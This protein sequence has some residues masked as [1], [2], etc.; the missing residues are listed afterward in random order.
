MRIPVLDTEPLES[1]LLLQILASLV[2]LPA[3][4]SQLVERRHIIDQPAD[5]TDALLIAEAATRLLALKDVQEA[6]VGRLPSRVDV[7]AVHHELH[8]ELAAQLQVRHHVVVVFA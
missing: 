4:L 8:D 7:V 6:L 1:V 3:K 2:L 5:E